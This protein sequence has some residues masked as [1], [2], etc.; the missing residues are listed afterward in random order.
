MKNNISS[1]SSVIAIDLFASSLGAVILL[2]LIT[3]PFMNLDVSA[4]NLIQEL[5]SKSERVEQQLADISLEAKE[6]QSN[7]LALE[8]EALARVLSVEKKAQSKVTALEQVVQAKVTA[9]EKE[10]SQLNAELEGATEALDK[11][12]T[13]VTSMAESLAQEVLSEFM[14]NV[15]L[16]DASTFTGGYKAYQECGRI[17]NVTYVIGDQ[18]GNVTIYSESS[19]ERRGKKMH[20]SKMSKG[21]LL[22]DNT[23]LTNY[24]KTVSMKGQW[25]NLSGRKSLYDPST[26]VYTA[27]FTCKNKK[28]QES[29]FTKFSNTVPDEIIQLMEIN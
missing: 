10:N 15:N 16:A 2:F 26:G 11:I 23:V 13:S 6:A 7:A 24:M 5:K 12:N 1:P 9:L 20:N 28:R 21:Y 22:R 3:V 27:F 25:S 18:L 29:I 4:A 8:N 14:E 19:T 17:S